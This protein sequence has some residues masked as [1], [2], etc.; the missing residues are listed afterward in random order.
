MTSHPD[1]V[2]PVY[3]EDM[4]EVRCTIIILFATKIEPD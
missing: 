2:L 4:K 1:Q 3:Y